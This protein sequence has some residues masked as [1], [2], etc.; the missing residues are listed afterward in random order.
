MVC[1]PFP[2]TCSLYLAGGAG[3][4][5]GAG[6]VPQEAAT[7]PPRLKANLN[8]VMLIGTVGQNPKAFTFSNSSKKV[9]FSV[10][11]NESFKYLTLSYFLISDSFHFLPPLSLFL[12]H[13]SFFASHS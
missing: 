3:Y 4:A 8:K 7:A 12:L 2:F 10:A 13:S 6:Y 9:T 11:T 1:S 5:E